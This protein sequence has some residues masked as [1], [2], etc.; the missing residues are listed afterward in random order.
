MHD[1]RADEVVWARRDD[2][3]ARIRRKV[4]FGKR[5][6]LSGVD[7]ISVSVADADDDHSLVRL[8]A[9]LSNTRRGLLTGVAI[10]PTAAAPLLG[11]V[12]AI[13]VHD[14]LL[15]VAGFPVGALLGSAGLYAGRRSL[16]HE[17]A[18]AERVLGLF[19]DD[20]GRDR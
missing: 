15:F 9:D 10:A 5:R 14:P 20:L 6:R 13:V 17:R 12:A 19:L 3:T 18:E 7:A 11:G 16:A 4:D 1:R 8:E 2:L